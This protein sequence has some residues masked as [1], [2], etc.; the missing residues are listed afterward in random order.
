LEAV[1]R[2]VTIAA[3]ATV[4]AESVDFAVDECVQAAFDGSALLSAAV[5]AGIR[6]RN[7]RL[8]HE[9]RSDG[10][11][12]GGYP[13]DHRSLLSSRSRPRSMTGVLT[14]SPRVRNDRRK[15]RT[16]RANLLN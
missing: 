1:G 6:C 16:L 7:G 11:I 10:E 13:F 15:K 5:D 8:R 3:G 2:H 4:T 12:A 14:D 9:Q